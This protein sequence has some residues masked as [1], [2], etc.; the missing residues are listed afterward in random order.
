MLFS[1]SNLNKAKSTNL[2]NDSS[3][4]DFK[5]NVKIGDYVEYKLTVIDDQAIDQ[6]GNREPNTFKI[7]NPNV[8]GFL[9]WTIT[10]INEKNIT[11]KIEISIPNFYSDVKEI[12]I[13]DGLMYNITTHEPFGY[14]PFWIS[15]ISTQEKNVTLAG[16]INN[17]LLGENANSNTQVD[18]LGGYRD[19]FE[20]DNTNDYVTPGL[21]QDNG[22]YHLLYS[23]F[24]GIM[25]ELGNP[26][27]PFFWISLQ[28]PYEFD[29]FFILDKSNLDF[30]SINYGY[31]LLTYIAPLWL[32]IFIIFGVVIIILGIKVKS[33]IRGRQV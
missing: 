2:I 17:P 22:I 21:S 23:K 27:S 4:K 8:I 9:R 19:V 25:V 15:L 28:F 29:T 3:N 11:L 24:N 16:T 10:G 31:T 6:D 18:Y 5:N 14:N 1:L 33:W 13:L 30:G 7:F 32:P 26:S 12:T 20:F